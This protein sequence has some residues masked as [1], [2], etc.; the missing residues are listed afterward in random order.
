LASASAISL[1]SAS[2]FYLSSAYSFVSNSPVVS[3]LVTFALSNSGSIGFFAFSFFAAF[4]LVSSF[5]S[6]TLSSFL[7]SSVDS[8]FLSPSASASSFLSPFALFSLILFF[9]YALLTLSRSAVNDF[10][11]SLISG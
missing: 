4:G 3:F 1:A 8:T 6:S 10:R 2:A 7:T 11:Y 5:F 9:A